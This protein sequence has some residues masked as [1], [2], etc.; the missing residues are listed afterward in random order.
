MKTHLRP[1]GRR[2]VIERLA[3]PALSE[4]GLFVLGREWPSLGRVLAIGHKLWTLED[5]ILKPHFDLDLGDLVYFN[6]AAPELRAVP[7]E[8][9]HFV[10]DASDLLARIRE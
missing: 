7:R 4:G 3:L 8:P 10:L 1:L 2:V 9:E 6:R 5:G